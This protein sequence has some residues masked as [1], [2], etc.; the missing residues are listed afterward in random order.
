LFRDPDFVRLWSIGGLTMT[1][2]WMEILVIGVYTY[3]VSGSAIVVAAMLF[4][5]TCPGLFLGAFAGA[6]VERLDRRYVLAG[7]LAV[8]DVSVTALGTIALFGEIELWHIAIGAFLNGLFWSLEF[9]TRR[10]LLG[11]VAGLQRIGAAMGLDSATNSGTR[12]LGPVLGGLL[13]DRYGLIGPYFLGALI[14]GIALVNTLTLRFRS[15]STEV[16]ER[17]VFVI[18]REGLAYLRTNRLLAGALVVTALVNFFGVSYTS[19][20]PVIG[21]DKFGLS[22]FPIGVMVSMEGLGAV[23]GGVA[24]ASLSRPAQFARIY[25]YGAYLYIGM[26]VIFSL[27][28]GFL[29]SLSCLLLGGVGMAGFGAMQSALIFSTTEARMRRRVMGVL[30]VCIGAAPLGVLHTGLLAELLGAD[31]AIRVIAVEGLAALSLCLWRWPE[32]GRV[33]QFTK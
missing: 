26:I 10:T 11:D 12:I 6:I 32:L 4:A 15:A 16:S 33:S 30:V 27:V 5:R 24:I 1:M 19:M 21:G 28:P 20:V 9:P 17:S 31:L 8:S 29:A 25:L 3:D 14:Y 18:L 23:L 7:A 13:F 22:A 2:R